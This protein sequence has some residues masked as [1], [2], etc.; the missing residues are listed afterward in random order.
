MVLPWLTFL[1]TLNLHSRFRYAYGFK[2]GQKVISPE[3]EQGFLSWR[4][5]T[6][7]VQKIVVI[8]IQSLFNIQRCVPWVVW[9]MSSTIITDSCVFHSSPEFKLLYQNCL[10]NIS[11]WMFYRHHQFKDPLFDLSLP[12]LEILLMHFLVNETRIHWGT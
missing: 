1:F 12:T 8:T 5:L 2:C 10:L 9:Y 4:N 6:V 7:T 11:S 3:L